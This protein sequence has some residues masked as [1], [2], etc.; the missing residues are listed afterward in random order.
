MKQKISISPYADYRKSDDIHGTALYPAVMVGPM[1]RELLKKYLSDESDTVTIL[2][3][4]V[5]S[6][7]ALYEAQQVREN[8]RLFGSDINPLAIL[9]S[10]VKL[11]G[12]CR[13]LIEE[14]VKR[15]TYLLTEVHTVPRPIDFSK[16]EKWFRPDIACSL[17]LIR[18]AVCSIENDKNRRYFWY[19]MIDIVRKYCNSRSSTYKLHIRPES[20]IH[21]IKNRVVEDY[22]AKVKGELCFFDDSKCRH[23]SLTLNQG[24]SLAYLAECHEDSFDLCI[25]SPPYGD[26]ET[27]VPYGQYSS[28]ALL[29]IDDKDLEMQGWELDTYAAI[30]SS[31]L[32][33]PN[34]SSSN[35]EN[36]S[37]EDELISN[38][39]KQ[40]CNRKQKKVIRF[41]R[42][43]QRCLDEIIRVTKSTIIMTLGDR[44]VDGLTIDLSGFTA[45]YFKR[46]GWRVKS[47]MRRQIPNKRMPAYVSRVGDKPVKSMK[48]ELV[49]IA[50]APKNE[51]ITDK[52]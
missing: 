47:E 25:T 20:Q 24:D 5:G 41:L 7:T 23:K 11:E 42:G 33:G 17:Q 9:I 2:D 21:N 13:E 22:I 15:L 35:L 31:S 39:I 3:P 43:Y 38:S 14:D 48:E 16:R 36:I 34:H 40:I 28:L 30:D 37:I 18:D 52:I 1:Q 46:F 45:R 10:R 4:F 49:L 51:A 8:L 26:N 27:T 44:T 50:E 12:I 29:W 6:G 19:M 32:G